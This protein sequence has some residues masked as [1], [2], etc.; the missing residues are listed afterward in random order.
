MIGPISAGRAVLSLLLFACLF[1]TRADSQVIYDLAEMTSDVQIIGQTYE[2]FLSKIAIFDFNDNG[3]ND[4][5]F[6]S[7]DIGSRGH[8]YGIFDQPLHHGLVIDLLKVEIHL[9]IY[10][11]YPNDVGY[12]VIR[13]DIN[14]DDIGDLVVSD[15]NEGEVHLFIGSDQWVPG[16]EINLANES[17][18]ITFINS[19]GLGCDMTS[20]DLNNDGLE[21][22]VIGA[23]YAANPVGW[24][25]GAVYVFFAGPQYAA[26]PMTIDL[27]VDQADLTIYGYSWQDQFGHSLTTGDVNNDGIRDLIVGAWRAV[28]A[29]DKLGRTYV[30]FGSGDWPDHHVIDLSSQSADA[31]VIGP[32][33]ASGLGFSVASGDIDGDGIDDIISAAHHYEGT[34]NAMGAGYMIKGRSSFM[35]GA[36]FNLESEPADLTCI[37]EAR[38]SELGISMGAGDLDGDGLDEWVICASNFTSGLQSNGKGFV[39]AGSPLIPPQHTIDF[40]V[41]QPTIKV[42]RHADDE[43]LTVSN[44]ELS[45][46]NGDGTDDLIL[47]SRRADMPGRDHCGKIYIFFGHAPL[48]APPRVLAGPGPHAANRAEVRLFNP[49]DHEQWLLRLAPYLVQG[50]GARVAAADLDG[51]GYDEIV[52][53]PGPGPHHPPLVTIFSGAGSLQDVFQ[54]YGTPNYGVNLAAG[55][56]DGD[57]KDEVVTGAGPGSVYGP[58]VRAWHSDSGS[59][60]PL[61]GAS[62]MAYGTLRW[63]VNVAC[64][65]LNGDGRDEI[66]TGAGPGEI[67]GPHVRAWRYSS[68]TVSPIQSISFMAYGTDQYGV[69]VA[70]GD[71]D[72]DGIDE[73]VTGPGPGVRFGSHVR[74]WN[75]DG[76]SLEPIGAISFLAFP[77]PQGTGGVVVACGDIDNDGNDEILTTPGPF[78]G[79]PPKLSTWNYDGDVLTY[80]ASKSFLLFEADHYFSGAYSAIGNFLEPADYLP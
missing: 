43:D 49:F 23:E 34:D 79:S 1:S 55:D 36:T 40:S 61:P 68:G 67:F 62:F 50:Y 74:G 54:A 6:G 56:L 13:C 71:I 32:Q 63:G 39:I 12:D 8:V 78:G 64:G 72:G 21:D 5:F 18:D 51:D 16:T 69:K 65:D 4:L 25:T 66:V 15:S 22:L 75:Y 41:H 76:Q 60:A 24:S 31:T 45:D 73:I 9:E 44:S 70:C 52:A 57:G 7:N 30:F 3:Q 33:W 29:S 58:H 77:G 27:A 59:M 42:L 19:Y 47:A 53:G 11:E 80:F 2:D 46:V 28:S 17:A 14:A 20:A 38:D 10:D 35:P 26:S 37:G 48:D